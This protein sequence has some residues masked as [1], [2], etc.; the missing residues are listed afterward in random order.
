MLHQCTLMHNYLWSIKVEVYRA[1]LQIKVVEK[2]SFTNGKGTRSKIE[3]GLYFILFYFFEGDQNK[4]M[5]MG[6]MYEVQVCSS[7]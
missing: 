5:L 6:G 1:A 7:I 4:C 3:C 2:V